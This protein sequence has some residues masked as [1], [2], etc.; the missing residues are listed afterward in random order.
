MK[1]AM[2]L[3]PLAVAQGANYAA[4]LMYARRFDEALEQ[5]RKT[6]ELDPNHIGAQAWLCHTLNL[7]GLYSE[8]LDIGQKVSSDPAYTQSSVF[9]CIGR[10][11]AGLGQRDKALQK[12]AAVKQVERTTYVASYWTAVIY[13]GLGDKEAAFAELEKSF[14]NHDWFLAKLKTDPFMDPLRDDPRFD[15]MVKR[16]NLPQ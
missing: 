7:K 8:A 11:Y 3:E 15:A 9:G 12:I 5:A 14:Q 6:Y 16:L 1:R 2:E 4:V 10:A 13:A